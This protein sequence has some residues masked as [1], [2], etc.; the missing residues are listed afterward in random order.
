MRRRLRGMAAMLLT[1]C[2]VFSAFYGIP[3]R[4]EGEDDE[5]NTITGLWV[6]EPIDWGEEGPY[7]SDNP[8]MRQE[9]EEDLYGD[10][11]YFGHTEE[12]GA[13]TADKLSIS[14][15]GNPAGETAVCKP[16]NENG[17]FVDLTFYELGEY[18]VEYTPEGGER[19]FCIYPCRISGGWFLYN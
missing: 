6:A 5:N 4:A 11:L 3:V 1:V 18:S 16:N 12:D 13:V 14:Y 9:T 19:E 15:E 7:L 10:T 2:M 17:D 8:E